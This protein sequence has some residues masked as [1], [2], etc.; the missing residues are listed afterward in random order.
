VA[1]SRQAPSRMASGQPSPPALAAVAGTVMMAF[2][3]LSE[4]PLAKTTSAGDPS[5]STNPVVDYHVVYAVILI[6]LAATYAGN[7]LGLGRLWA[8]LVRGAPAG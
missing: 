2:M 1:G 3:W 6:A 7:T 4:W 8:A 5:M